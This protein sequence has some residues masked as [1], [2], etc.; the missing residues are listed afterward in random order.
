MGFLLAGEIV[1]R[2]S[3]RP[4]RDF[5]RAEV[6]QKLGMADTSLGLGGRKIPDTMQ[7]QVDQHTDWDWNS[8]YWRNLCSPW[9]GVHS[10]ASDLSRWLRYFVHPDPPVLR[11]ETAAAMIT[12]QTQGLNLP[13][14]LGWVTGEGRLA[15]GASPRTFGHSGSTGTMAWLD[16]EKD[17]SLVLLTTQ[18]LA[19]SQ[20][21]LLGPVSDLI[22]SADRAI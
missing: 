22:A 21:T 7:C 5:L 1:E 15:K 9:G 2:V 14:G 12:N 18:P 17:L 10:T 11:A 19:V 16:P 4:L 3:R 6:F 13:W 8:A 20:K